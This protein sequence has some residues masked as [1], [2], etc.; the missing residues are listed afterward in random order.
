MKQR[1]R[2]K[3][4]YES[5]A[6]CNGWILDVFV[7]ANRAI[8]WIKTLE[9]QILKLFDTYEPIFYVLPK[10]EDAGAEI[11]QMLS[12]EVSVTRVEWANKFTDLFDRRTKRLI[13]II[14]NQCFTIK[15][16][17]NLK[18]IQGLPGYTIP[19]YLT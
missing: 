10:D 9:E 11:F 12:H 18:K 8:I 15:R 2:P 19:T 5:M 14:L 13:C 1:G 6:H 17:E 16:L 3:R 7:E 4:N